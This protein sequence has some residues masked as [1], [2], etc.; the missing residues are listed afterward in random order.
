[1]IVRLALLCALLLV[2]AGLVAREAQ[3]RWEQPLAVPPQGHRLTVAPGDSLRSVAADL[4]RAGVLPYPRML[5][6]YG[7]WTGLDA[8][9]KRG[10]YQL[11]QG[12]TAEQLLLL[13]QQG[14]VVQY[15]VTLPEGIT[16]ARAAQ[17]LA[18]EPLLEA[19]LAGITDPRLLALIAPHT[20]PERAV[21]PG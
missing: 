11:T 1:M 3:R 16:L 18:R 12:L 7:R 14:K 20:N 8:Q 2:L 15:R 19:E 6:A 10:E 9:V 17:L 21:L 4:S 13:L 5:T